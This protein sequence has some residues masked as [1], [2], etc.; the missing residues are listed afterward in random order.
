MAKTKMTARPVPAVVELSERRGE[1]APDAPV[2]PVPD[3]EVAAKPTRSRFTAEY[4]LRILR[5]AERWGR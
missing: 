5:E 4:K 3:P 2:S 1:R